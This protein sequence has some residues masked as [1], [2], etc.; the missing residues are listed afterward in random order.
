MASTRPD[1][2][3]FPPDDARPLDEQIVLVVAGAE[4]RCASV[5]EIEGVLSHHVRYARGLEGSAISDADLLRD[6]LERVADLIARLEAGKLRFDDPELEEL[7][8][9][10]CAIQSEWAAIISSL[11]TERVVT[12][13]AKSLGLGKYRRYLTLRI[14]ALGGSAGSRVGLSDQRPG[15]APGLESSMTLQAPLSLEDPLE[16]PDLPREWDLEPIGGVDAFE[17]DFVP[18]ASD[19]ATPGQAPVGSAGAGGLSFEEPDSIEDLEREQSWIESRLAGQQESVESAG[20]P[21]NPDDTG[22]TLGLDGL[23]LDS[24]GES[25]ALDD[26]DDASEW[27]LTGLSQAEV[28]GAQPPRRRVDDLPDPW[29]DDELEDDD[30]FDRNDLLVANFAAQFELEPLAPDSEA[31]REGGDSSGAPED[32]DDESTYTDMDESSPELGFGGAMATAPE[33][34]RDPRRDLGRDLERLAPRPSHTPIGNGWARLPRGREVRL[35]MEDRK[36]VEIMLADNRFK[37]RIG[38]RPRLIDS[39]HQ[40]YELTEGTNSIGRAPG[41]DIV[42]DQRYTSISRVHLVI[43]IRQGRLANL[44]DNSGHGTYVPEKALRL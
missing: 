7:V 28:S 35:V 29:N 24:E 3:D 39:N 31:A 41:N 18:D 25:S 33:P 11:L 17:Q 16:A 21:D 40:T 37:L 1:L 26:Y 13:D 10:P 19:A 36:S 42:V 32:D 14:Q 12:D 22:P 4:R 44:C 38:S 30:T 27:S 15:P 20:E 23:S 6:E 2:W 9:S 34:R 43:E 5:R 8:F